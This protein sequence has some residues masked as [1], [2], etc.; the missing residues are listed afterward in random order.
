MIIKA[1]HHLF[2]Y[3]FF[4][5]YAVYK[6]RRHFHE[7]IISGE[8]R[9]KGLPVLL[10]SNH[11]SWWDGFWAMYLNLKLL[12]RKFYFMMLE[13]QL[14]KYSFFINTGGYSVK[15]G[16]RSVIESLDY[17]VNILS[18]KRNMVLLFPQG[19]IS[20]VYEQHIKFERG[21][22]RIMKEVQGRVQ[23]IYMAN[24]VEY[25]SEQKPSLHIYLMEFNK[26]DCTMEDI[27][28]EY[29]IFYS[30]AVDE[31]IKKAGS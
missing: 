14:K 5:L 21:L 26:A 31:N 17:T 8:V 30:A 15:K 23:V 7:V 18:D 6:I 10:I 24:L 1:R 27:E 11:I 13:D 28:K 12:H 29:N 25:F 20:S 22:E 19:R 2:I 16:S 9:E 3:P 4:K